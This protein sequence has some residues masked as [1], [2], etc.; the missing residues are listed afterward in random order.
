M[1]E[2]LG[3]GDNLSTYVKDLW[4]SAVTNLAHLIWLLRNAA[5]FNEKKVD[6]NKIKVTLLALVKE[7]CC[8]SQSSMHNTVTDLQII[9]KLGVSTRARPTPCI[10]SCRWILPWY[11]EIKLNCDSSTME[12]P[13]KAGLGV[14]A[15]TQTGD[16]LRV[17]T[18]GMGIMNS[19]EAECFAIMEVLSWAIER[20]WKKVWIEAD[21]ST[22]VMSFNAKEVPWKHRTK[23][24]GMT[25][26]LLPFASHPPGR[27]GIFQPIKLP[28]KGVRYRAMKR[29]TLWDLLVSLLGLKNLWLTILEFLSM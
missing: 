4:R 11:E 12:N 7:F 15:R 24:V 19:L 13:G 6:N 5:I 16:V 27:K 20:G 29:K 23:W 26:F 9:L 14:I 10:K 22:A 28:R 3:M 21:S 1:K 17:K 18:K 2:A 25:I 8:L